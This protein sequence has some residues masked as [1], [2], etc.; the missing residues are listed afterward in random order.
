MAGDYG[1]S[2]PKH[3]RLTELALKAAKEGGNAFDEFWN[4][5]EWQLILNK[6]CGWVVRRRKL[7][8]EEQDDL[9]EELKQRACIQAKQALPKFRGDA[10]VI[11]WF[12]R[13]LDTIQLKTS[14]T[15]KKLIEAEEQ[16]VRLWLSSPS[17][18]VEIMAAWNESLRKFTPEERRVYELIMKGHEPI[19]IARRLYEL[20]PA[21]PG[22]DKEP[23]DSLDDERRAAERKQVYAMRARIREKLKSALW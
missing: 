23:W 22:D 3:D 20:K 1:A 19:E 16:A 2:G 8:G 15:K 13:A 21:K 4:D 5:P 17:Q 10:S 12:T 11:T 9:V 18:D 7:T 6:K 14:V